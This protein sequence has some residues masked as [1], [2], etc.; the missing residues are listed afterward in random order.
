MAIP[1]V[2]RIM[3]TE[4]LGALFLGFPAK[5]DPSYLHAAARAYEYLFMLQ[6]PRL[7]R[8]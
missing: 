2:I 7:T 3:R 5:V 4:G 6:L 8:Y 1:S